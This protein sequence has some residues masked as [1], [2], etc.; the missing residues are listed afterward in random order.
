MTNYY[1]T[2]F[3]LTKKVRHLCSDAR[4]TLLKLFHFPTYYT[5]GKRQKAK[6]VSSVNRCLQ[7]QGAATPFSWE[8][9]RRQPS[10]RG[11]RRRSSSHKLLMHRC[12]HSLHLECQNRNVWCRR[13]KQIKGV[14]VKLQFSYYY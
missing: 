12:L 11:G 14:F 13:L 7:D 2:Y 8:E 9:P 1:A 5:K 4:A 3:V 10:P 6:R